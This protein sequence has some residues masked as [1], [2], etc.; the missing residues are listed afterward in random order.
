MY[1]HENNK[2]SA[3]LTTDLSA[4]YDT[5]DNLILLNK[6]EHY[7]IRGSALNIFKSYLSDRK[8]FVEI[9]THKSQIKNSLPCSVVQGGKLSGILYTLYTNEIP[10]LHQ[11]M[12]NDWFYKLTKN[13][14]VIYKNIDHTTV[15]FVDDST[16][17]IAFIDHSQIKSY[18][19][20]YYNLIQSYYN[21]N[22]LKIN[23]DKTQLLLIYKNKHKENLK[24]FFFKAN[25]FK[26]TPKKVIT[27]LGAHLREDLKLDTQI[28]NLVGQLHNRIFEIKQ[29]SKY[30]NFKTRL[31]FV[32]AHVIGKLTYILPLYS[33]ANQIMTNKLHK[34]LMTAAR[35]VIGNYCFKKSINY[36]LSKCNWLNINKMISN[37]SLKLINGIVIDKTPKAIYNLFKINRRAVVDINLKYI[38]KSKY[39][40][41][42]FLYKE[43]KNYNKLPQTLKGLSKFK[44]KKS[45]KEY[46]KSTTGADTRD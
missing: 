14:R 36:I 12:H 1:N 30:T 15:N 8:Q 6:L 41:Q 7:G 42:F 43:L 33:Q 28:G 16:N 45:I 22:K 17:V 27:I 39:Y 9:D 35:C 11:L 31:D 19:T 10:L 37:A 13:S 21:I 29:I 25:Q 26:I 5:V 20:Q 18:L 38:P 44:F 23:A 46:L 2:I 24:N 40:E 32:N 4:A 34:V 3:T